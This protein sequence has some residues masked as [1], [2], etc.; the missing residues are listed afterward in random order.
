LVICIHANRKTGAL[1][2]HL[3]PMSQGQ[4]RNDGDVLRIRAHLQAKVDS[5]F[6]DVLVDMG[7]RNVELKSSRERVAEIRGGNNS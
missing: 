3:E 4:S 5:N 1:L 6:V 2:H 7:I